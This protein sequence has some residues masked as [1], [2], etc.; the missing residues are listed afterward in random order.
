MPLYVFV[1]GVLL[2]FSAYIMPPQFGY[3]TRTIL[4][5]GVASGGVCLFLVAAPDIATTPLGF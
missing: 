1:F 2:S 5:T 4:A 3:I